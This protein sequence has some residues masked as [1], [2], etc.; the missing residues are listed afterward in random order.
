MKPRVCMRGTKEGGHDS[1]RDKMRAV[2]EHGRDVFRNP[3][4]RLY[5]MFE[6]FCS[7]NLG[8]E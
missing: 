2:V 6:S 7:K 5:G 8:V 4:S 3:V 1:R